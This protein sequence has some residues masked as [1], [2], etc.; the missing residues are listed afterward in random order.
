PSSFLLHP[1]EAAGAA[2]LI[3]FWLFFVF[4]IGLVVGS[5]LNVC[6]ARMP[7]EK[8]LLWPGSRC[9][10]CLQP[11]RWYDNLPVISY[12]VLRGRCRTC[13]VSFSPRY[14]FVELLTGLGFSGLFYVEMVLNVHDWPHRGQPWAI[15]QGLYPWQW[16]AGYAYHAL[17][18]SFLMVASAC[19]LSGRWIPFPLTLT[20]T[21]VGLIGAACFPWPWPH[22]PEDIVARVRGLPPIEQNMFRNGPWWQMDFQVP[23]GL[24]PWPMWGPL[25]DWAPMGSWQL[26]LATGL[27]GM[28]A[29]TFVMRAVAFLFGTGLGKEALGLGDA[30]LM[31]MA[32]AF[33]GWQAVIIAFFV[34]V[35][36]ALVFAVVQLIV[37]RD[38]SLPYGPSLAAGIIITMLG[39]AWIGP[40]LQILFFWGGLM[41]ALAVVGAA[42]MFGSAYV[43]RLGRGRSTS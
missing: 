32:G 7:F 19:D 18:F 4:V 29:G 37:H 28:L 8:S 1:L 35:F 30:D 42:F 41:L 3:W 25:P 15:A 39:W 17:L 21:F 40:R 12:L 9:G 22:T 5:F 23:Q 26:G 20:G 13:G 31:M 24:Y 16:W 38:N 34:S 36:P 43:L 27:V 2:M 10:N 14:F 11:I 33:L 6:V